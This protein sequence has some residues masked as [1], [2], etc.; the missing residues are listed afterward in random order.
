MDG[1][2]GAGPAPPVAL[3]WGEKVVHGGA[4]AV[5]PPDGYDG[6]EPDLGWVRLED[7][8][9][10]VRTLPWWSPRQV[11]ASIAERARQEISR[12]LA[13]PPRDRAK[14]RRKQGTSKKT[15]SEL[16][17]EDFHTWRPE[18][19]PLLDRA[20]VHEHC[21][22]QDPGEAPPWALVT[23]RHDTCDSTF[24][25]PRSCGLR[26]CPRCNGERFAETLQD[27]AAWL[28]GA[29]VGPRSVRMLT[30]TMR[31]APVLAAGVAT[32]IKN[33]K[34]LRRRPFFKKVVQGGVVAIQWTK[35]GAT[36]HV[37]AHVVMVGKYVARE[38]VVEAWREICGDEE[39]GRGSGVDVRLWK[40][41]PEDAIKEAIGY[42]YPTKQRLYP[43]LDD[44]G[45]V[46]VT[47][48]GRRLIQKFGILHK[49]AKP[50]H[51]RACP[52]CE[53]T[54]SAWK[55]LGPPGPEDHAA[56]LV[57]V[58]SD[59]HKGGRMVVVSKG[60]VVRELEA[61]RIAVAN[62]RFERAE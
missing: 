26:A 50:K 37:H 59:R 28:D 19:G 29:N 31:N 3:S 60:R 36:W 17:E 25:A 55:V 56:F 30:L 11:A 21:V 40:S 48:K 23:L 46:E 20:R 24:I 18:A 35:Y 34:L 44:F 6:P 45:E 33:V 5:Q 57:T 22:M 53:I 4:D 27:I 43:T 41:A 61:A 14:R 54:D 39:L 15:E 38:R 10:R 47:L 58:K 51:E 62:A 1:T 7:R 9:G 12:E 16:T 42:V 2:E 13:A 32:I 49:I 52:C 8:G